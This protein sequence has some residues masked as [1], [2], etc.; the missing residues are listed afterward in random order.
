M[1]FKIKNELKK[2]DYKTLTEFLKNNSNVSIEL[3]PGV[4]LEFVSVSPVIV[5]VESF[6]YKINTEILFK[7]PIGFQVYNNLKLDD[8]VRSSLAVNRRNFK[9]SKTVTEPT[10]LE[11]DLNMILKTVER[12]VNHMF[13]RFGR[14]V[15]QTF[16]LNSEWLDT[17]LEMILKKEELEKRSE[18][19]K[20]F[21][22]IHVK[23]SK[24]ANERAGDLIPLYKEHDKTYLYDAKRVYFLLPHDFVANLLRCDEATMVREE[25]F[26]KR[27]KAVLR[28]LVYKKRLRKHETLD[29]IVCYYGL[30]EKTRR[31]LTKHLKHKTSRF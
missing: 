13:N 3:F 9:L 4:D 10:D 28:D 14:V 17:Q 24:E 26:D 22:T 29:G 8:D 15:E 23:S 21:G 18:T 19:P 6:G 16:T 1:R 30:N 11:K 5:A 25:E 20:P 2:T 27:G 31:Y 12:I 7:Q